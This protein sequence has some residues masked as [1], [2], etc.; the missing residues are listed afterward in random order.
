MPTDDDDRTG[1]LVLLR[2]SDEDE[3]AK[4][5]RDRPQ[6]DSRGGST[7]GPPGE[8]ANDRPAR[9]ADRKKGGEVAGVEVAVDELV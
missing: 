1:E 9:P 3:G 7:L 4:G 2:A 6:S 5:G 8:Q